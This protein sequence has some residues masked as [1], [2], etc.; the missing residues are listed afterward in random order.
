MIG[1]LAYVLSRPTPV[2][3]SYLF[4]DA[5][6]YLVPAHS[7]AYGEGWSFDGI[8][9]TSGF[10]VLYGYVAAAVA[11]VTGLTPALPIVMA[12]VSA[13]ALIAGAHLLL[14]RA[15]HLY[16]PTIAAASLLVLL[17]SPYVFRQIT[18]GL[19]WS[20]VVM[21]TTLC[22]GALLEDRPRAWLV[23][24]T[25]F[26]AV[27][28]RV[29]LALFIAIFTLAIAGRNMRSVVSA[30]AG[31][32]AAIALTALNSW[33]ITGA[34]TPNAVSTKQFWAST[35]D[36]LPA[37]SWPRLMR[38]TGPGF[39]ITELRALLS[40]RSFL[41]FAAIGAGIIALCVL[42][43]RKDARRAGLAIASTIAIGAYTL[44]YARGANIMGDHYSGAI[45]VPVFVLTC[46]LLSAAAAYRRVVAM[47]IGLAAM[48]LSV[49]GP[50]RAPGHLGIALGAPV[51]IA[52]VPPESRVA[53]W[54]A[55]LAGWQSGKRVTNLDGLANA[56]VVSSM[57]DGTLACY[58][59]DTRITHIMDY[60]FMFA[61]QI[62]TG[63][64]SDEGAR[65]R[66]L[67]RRNGYDSARLYGCTSLIKSVPDPEIPSQYR[68]F[69]LDPE[70]VSAVCGI[71]RH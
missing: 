51:L 41:M 12:V 6:Y 37:V 3:L 60:G 10:Q 20:W 19:E 43:R 55:G 69:A 4:D 29:D 57:K 58:L 35:T 49:R 70:C 28:V 26:A 67:M 53:A 22:V 62:D 27:L 13:A 64:S 9:R 14:T 65:R 36:F 63:F 50:W 48:A 68:L 42:E 11:L 5:F 34:W 40:V 32:A 44:A 45:M 1:W 15:G 52:A 66:M 46:A 38:V 16:G 30:A 17:A 2:M 24:L 59:R 47:G 7:F 18:G 8:T 23:A 54:N 56:E 61:G 39:V 71:P 31:A 33:L 25:A 21:A